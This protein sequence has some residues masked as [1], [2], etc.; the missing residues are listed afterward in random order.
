L[1]KYFSV[2]SFVFPL[3]HL[4]IYHFN[5]LDEHIYSL[6]IQTKNWNFNQPCWVPKYDFKQEFDWLFNTFGCGVGKGFERDSVGVL[7]REQNWSWEHDKDIVLE[8]ACTM[9]N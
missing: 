2:G 3:E 1:I 9:K 5:A 8:F 6:N 7:L 4:E